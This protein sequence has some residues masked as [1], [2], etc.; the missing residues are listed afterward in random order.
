[1]ASTS[2]KAFLREREALVHL[3]KPVMENPNGEAPACPKGWR[4]GAWKKHLARSAPKGEDGQPQEIRQRAMMVWKG[5]G[6]TRTG[7]RAAKVWLRDETKR[8][9]AFMAAEGLPFKTPRCSFFHI[10]AQDDQPAHWR[11]G[12]FEANHTTPREIH[13]GATIADALAEVDRSKPYIHIFTQT[14]L[15]V[16]AEENYPAPRYIVGTTPATNPT[17][18][19]H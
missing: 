19:E 17:S 4:P 5:R 12:I 3:S 11:I 6:E 7:Q 18:Q 2:M 9:K 16:E 15:G 1:M 13:T 14:D 10:E 8:L